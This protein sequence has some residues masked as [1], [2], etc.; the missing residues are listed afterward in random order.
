MY[1]LTQICLSDQ[2]SLYATTSI[3]S[4]RL[5]FNQ[6]MP[7]G[8]FYLHSSDRSIPNISDVWSVFIITLFIE[9][10]CIFNANS[11]DPD[12]TPRSVASDLG[13]HCLQMSYL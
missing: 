2:Y 13:L 11:V 3:G 9:I 10:F 4:F 1:S 12:Q 5:V 7:N 6:F 8:F